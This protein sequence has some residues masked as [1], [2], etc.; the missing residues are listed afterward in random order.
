MNTFLPADDAHVAILQRYARAAGV[1]MLLSIVFGF[2][3]EMYLPGRIIVSGDAAATALNIRANPTLFR[4]TFASYLVEGICDVM[5]LV[6]FYVLLKPVD[7][8]L[9]LLSAF[10]GVVSMVTFAIGQSSFFAA[11]LILRDT[12]GMTAFPIQQREALALLATR[13]ASMIAALFLCMYGI[14]SMIR[15]Y[16]IARSGYLPRVIGFLLVA[17]GLGFFLRSITY[18]VAPSLSSPHLLLPMALA[19][20]PLMAWLMFRGVNGTRS[21]TSGAPEQY[22]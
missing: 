13:L 19:G 14:A 5:L 18:L 10:F 11:S 12:G 8:N 1:A 21:P 22:S 16:L 17:G 2:L 15:G 9:A 20:I 7:R 6:F 4:L 3:G